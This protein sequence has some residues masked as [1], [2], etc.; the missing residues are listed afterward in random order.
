[1][2]KQVFS[3]EEVKPRPSSVLSAY[4]YDPVTD[5]YIYFIQFDGFS[6]NYY[7]I[8]TPKGV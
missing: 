3:W 4:T 8:L 6:I 5:R 2:V 1:M 7:I